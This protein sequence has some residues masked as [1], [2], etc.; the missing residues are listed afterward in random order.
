VDDPF[1]G[2]LHDYRAALAL[3]RENVEARLPEI[4]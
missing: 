4:L 1:G 3:L 2:T